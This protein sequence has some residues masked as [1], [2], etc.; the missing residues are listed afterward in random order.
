[1]LD[2][3]HLFLVSIKLLLLYF[4]LHALVF[5]LLVIIQ[6]IGLLTEFYVR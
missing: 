6:N 3:K 1:M 2:K 5:K 4:D